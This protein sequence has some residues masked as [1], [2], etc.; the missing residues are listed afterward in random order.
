MVR[1]KRYGA[2]EVL[3]FETNPQLVRRSLGEGGSAIE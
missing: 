2:T 3:F 1:Q